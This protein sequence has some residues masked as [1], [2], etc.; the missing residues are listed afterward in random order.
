MEVSTRSDTW[1]EKC[2]VTGFDVYPINA[3]D[4]GADSIN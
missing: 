3:G 1:L 2:E 4:K